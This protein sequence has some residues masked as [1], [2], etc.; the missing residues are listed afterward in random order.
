MRWLVLVMA[1]CSTQPLETPSA[2]VLLARP[3]PARELVLRPA[4]PAPEPIVTGIP[5]GSITRF[6]VTDDGRAAVTS[7]GSLRLWPVLDGTREPVAIAARGTTAGLAI[8]R[9]GTG[10]VIARL[11]D[12]GTLELI[13]TTEAGAL[14]SRVTVATERALEQVWLANGIALAL[15]DDGAVVRI[16][17]GRV[18]GRLVPPPGERIRTILVRNRRALALFSS[19]AGSRGRW[20]GD[21]LAWVDETPPLAVTSDLV[22]VSADHRLLATTDRKTRSVVIL[23]LATGTRVRAVTRVRR[24]AFEFLQIAGFLADGSLGIV[25]DGMLDVWR[26]GKHTSNVTRHG[27]F[28]PPIATERTF[29]STY[30]HQLA[31]C[32]GTRTRYLGYH[33]SGPQQIRPTSTGLL[34]TTSTK[35]YQFDD[36]LALRERYKLGDSYHV[37]PVDDQRALVSGKKGVALVEIATGKQLQKLSDTGHADYHPV[38]RLVALQDLNKL[39]LAIYQ[40]RAR[41][42]GPLVPVAITE[43]LDS[44]VKLL[45]PAISRGQIAAVIERPFDRFETTV[46]IREIRAV[47][48]AA[49]ESIVYGPVRE[50]TRELLDLGF[51]I[52]VRRKRDDGYAV[53]LGKSRVTLRDPSGAERWAIPAGEIHDA[54][55][56][57]T[58]ELVVIGGGI[59]VLDVATGGFVRRQCGWDFRLADEPSTN[60]HGRS[61]LC[62]R[63]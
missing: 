5:E 37:V 21:P 60:G 2:P 61:S 27:H 52:S 1:A 44:T 6:A 63:E 29:V 49:E 45:D 10:F 3:D 22:A 13:R 14:E 12:T 48:P 11:D 50:R 40:P 30:D 47:R 24:D 33:V 54:A 19:P 38:T 8:E 51:P 20:I 41:R 15:T 62:T 34:V 42:V 53:E 36:Q 26:D 35:L 56:M 18:T 43:G 17:N 16:A 9:V 28:I 58:G 57:A 31:L 4:A 7:S 59:G 46:T 32:D 39:Q 23:E 25:V 55:W